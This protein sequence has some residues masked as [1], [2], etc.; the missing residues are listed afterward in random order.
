MCVDERCFFACA[1]RPTN[2]TRHSQLSHALVLLP[3]P[4]TNQTHTKQTTNTTTENEK[5][6]DRA[7]RQGRLVPARRALA[8][9]RQG[10]ARARVIMMVMVTERRRR[11]RRRA[12]PHDNRNNAQQTTL[13]CALSPCFFSGPLPFFSTHRRRRCISSCLCVHTKPRCSAKKTQPQ[14]TVLLRFKDLCL[15]TPPP[16]LA[17]PFCRCFV[18]GR[19][20]RSV[21]GER[22]MAGVW[23]GGGALSVVHLPL[24]LAPPC[25]PFTVL[26][27]PSFYDPPRVFL[28]DT[29]G[30]RAAVAEAPPRRARTRRVDARAVG[31]WLLYRRA[32]NARLSNTN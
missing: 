16:L 26:K 3:K 21:H 9:G 24:N 6:C 12:A 14:P 22:Q 20:L 17:L 11:A 10:A 4:P 7:A 28:S 29:F 18:E 32:G 1:C 5:L 27:K 15:T 30:S 25:P 23:Q 13:Q 8:Q 2:N 19:V 31:P